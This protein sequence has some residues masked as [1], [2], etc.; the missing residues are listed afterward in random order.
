[1]L[2]IMYIYIY[3]SHMSICIV[4]SLIACL[5]IVNQCDIIIAK[6]TDD[7]KIQLLPP[8]VVVGG[9]ILLLWC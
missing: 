5:C 2:R 9:A 8:H 3:V 1:M 4:V 6:R 7:L